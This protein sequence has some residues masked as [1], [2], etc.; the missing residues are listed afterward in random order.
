MKIIFVANNWA[1][2]HQQTRL[3][4]LLELN[5]PII[6]LAVFR[7]YY[8]FHALIAPI[9][10]GTMSHATYPKRIGVYLR[11]FSQIFRRTEND[12]CIY[13]YGFDLMLVTFISRI[14]FQRKFKI[15]YEVPDIRELFFSPS[16][17]G[18][19]IRWIEKAV[20]PCIDYL[21]LL[22]PNLFQ[23]TSFT[24]EKSQFLIIGS[25]KTKFI[26]KNF[27]IQVLK[28]IRLF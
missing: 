25:L 5:F 15:V 4:A 16:L 3:H 1:D 14:V 10:I 8:P 2:A 12:D 28:L 26:M 9:R 19:L 11:L 23:N 20:I 21:L 18:K 24:C 27:N 7:D 6:C 22:P 17:A 13:V